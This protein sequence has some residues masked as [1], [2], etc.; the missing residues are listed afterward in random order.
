MC[1]EAR[2]ARVDYQMWL[3]PPARFSAAAILFSFRLI[4]HW[5]LDETEATQSVNCFCSA[6]ASCSEWNIEHLENHRQ[7]VPKTSPT[8]HKHVAKASPTLHHHI[9]L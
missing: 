8:Q 9:I 5:R 4:G 2:A 3:A 1:E 7:N 6:A